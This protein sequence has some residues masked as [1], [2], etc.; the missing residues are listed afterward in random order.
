VNDLTEATR[1]LIAGFG[2]VLRGDDGFGPAVIG[3]LEA[4]GELP[5]AVRTAELGIAGLGLV[6]E[7]LDGYA[8]LVI[9]DAVDRGGVPGTLY[10]LDVEVP[11]IE[12]LADH[13]RHAWAADMHAA[14]PDR[15]LLVAQAAG[16]LPPRVW[17]VG[18]QPEDTDDFRT[19]LSDSVRQAVGRAAEIVRALVM[20]AGGSR[21]AS[22]RQTR[23]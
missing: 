22:C 4:E 16:V 21:S 6:Q 11:P 5:V 12:S 8:A 14:V 2:N 15:A 19:D 23:N 20:E 1:I 3:A 10:V 7:L 13:E 18:C 9:V 17:L